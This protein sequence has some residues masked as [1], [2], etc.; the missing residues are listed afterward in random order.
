MLQL[1][2]II[3]NKH[4]LD[5][6]HYIETLLFMYICPNYIYYMIEHIHLHNYTADY[7]SLYT[8]TVHTVNFP[9]C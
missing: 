2:H 6:C 4:P 3:D 5:G 9:Q 8:S 7:I 1:V